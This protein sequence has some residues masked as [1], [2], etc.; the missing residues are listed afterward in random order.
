[1]TNSKPVITQAAENFFGTVALEKAQLYAKFEEVAARLN[2]NGRVNVAVV[3]MTGSIA[4]SGV[5]PEVPAGLWSQH[6][7]AIGA[8]QSGKIPTL[9]VSTLGNGI[10]V[11][12]DRDGTIYIPADC[13]QQVETAV[14]A[15]F[16]HGVNLV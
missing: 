13:K 5:A 4:W 1:M 6:L 15:A 14:L 3:Y 16:W 7:K 8:S 11:G 10:A 2:P 9:V 12:L